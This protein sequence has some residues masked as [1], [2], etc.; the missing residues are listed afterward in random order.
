MI[1]IFIDLYLL[2][3]KEVNALGSESQVLKILTPER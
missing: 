2:E 3:F 1:Y